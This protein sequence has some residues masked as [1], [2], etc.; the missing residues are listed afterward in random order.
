MSLRVLICALVVMALGFCVVSPVRAE[1]LAEQTLWAGRTINAGKVIV[2]VDGENLIITYQTANGWQLVNT[3]LYV[4]GD[5][6][7]KAAPGRFEYQH[8][9]LGGVTTDTYVIPFSDID[10]TIWTVYIAA[11]AD[12]QLPKAGGYQE[13]TAWGEGWTLEKG[14]AMYFAVTFREPPQ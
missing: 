6:L 2:A 13:E 9:S 12:V 10:P 3:H 7:I 11:H 5:P 1:V 14:W 8:E 4:S